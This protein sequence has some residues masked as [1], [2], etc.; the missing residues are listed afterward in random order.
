MPAF[1]CLLSDVCSLLFWCLLGSV[2]REWAHDP[3]SS[4]NENVPRPGGGVLR[5]LRDKFI[6]NQN[7]IRGLVSTLKGEKGGGGSV[8]R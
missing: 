6:V 7:K 8:C 3:V 5:F 1:C 4:H 2:R